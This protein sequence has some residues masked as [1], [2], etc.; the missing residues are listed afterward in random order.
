M[1]SVAPAVEQ[2]HAKTTE[3]SISPSAS[4]VYKVYPRRFAV[5][6]IFCICSL[7]NGFQWIEYAIIQNIIIRYYNQSLAGDSD[8]QNNAV[9][10][11]SLSYMVTS[12]TISSA[13]TE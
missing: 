4:R 12:E 1:I 10:W 3:Q 9:T 6:A 13:L 5:L 8:A 2:Q 7:S 11:T